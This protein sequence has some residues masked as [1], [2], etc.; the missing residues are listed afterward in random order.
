MHHSKY[1][2]LRKPELQGFLSVE[3][4]RLI[5]IS[6]V[7]PRRWEKNYLDFTKHATLYGKCSGD[8]EY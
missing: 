6:D 1:T 8:S 5:Y 7:F 2:K 4:W 3:M